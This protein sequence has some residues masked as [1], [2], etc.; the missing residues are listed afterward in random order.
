MNAP[1]QTMRIAIGALFCVLA[2]GAAR[3]QDALPGL[4]RNE[5]E[6][7]AVARRATL[8]VKDPLAVFG[9]VLGQLPDRV[10]VLPTESYY[11]FGFVLNGAPY[12]GNIRLA[13]ND[14]D[15]GKV[16][17][18]Y[19][20]RPSDLNPRPEA[21]HVVLGAAHGVTVEKLSPL[22]YR[23]S[24]AGKTV[25]F[26]LNDLS[27]V[28]PPVGLLGAD[29]KFLGPIFD[30]SAIRF[31]LVFNS[32]L[33]VFHYLLDDSAGVA[34]EFVATKATDRI[35]IGKRTG[36]AFYRDT[37]GRRILIGVGRRNSLLNT[38]YDGP[39][40]QL[41]DNF[42]EG[43]ALRDA[44]LAASPEAKGEIDRFG[45]FANGK[46]RYLIHPFLRYRGEA[47][48]TVFHRCATSKRVAEAQRPRCFVIAD[49]DSDKPNP[50]PLALK[51]R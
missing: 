36:F 35:S 22:R 10:S 39:F 26:A 31:F 1:A 44:I 17:F 43:E 4:D 14:R 40:D 15:Q 33:K 30:E 48:L 41:P 5:I 11:Y 19:G 8:D 47:D 34:D 50:Q 13:A 46:D 37:R 45:N 38:Y 29:E 32:R 28:K 20:D 21:R 6:I 7:G 2:L 27:R 16:H 25:E 23:I 9:F 3:A 12:S 49:E 24:H 42:I 51:R 18:S